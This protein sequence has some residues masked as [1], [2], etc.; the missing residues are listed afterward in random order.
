MTL[1]AFFLLAFDLIFHLY[2]GTLP[3]ILPFLLI[4]PS[5]LPAYPSPPF[6]PIALYQQII[7][8]LLLLLF[9]EDLTFLD[10]CQIMANE[11]ELR[12]MDKS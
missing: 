3:A 1:S 11:M 8:Q 12:S 5:L 7:F 10:F 2:T 9:R 4:P 6:L